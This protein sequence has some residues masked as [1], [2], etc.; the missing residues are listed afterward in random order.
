[1]PTVFVTCTMAVVLPGVAVTQTAWP[2]Q[3]VTDTTNRI[4]ELTAAPATP[5]P[6]AIEAL[7]SYG[8]QAPARLR[9]EL[10]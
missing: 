8:C 2:Y 4:I 6:E 10:A 3:Y 9:E 5:T 7:A 1:M